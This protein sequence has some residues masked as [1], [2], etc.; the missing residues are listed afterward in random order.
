MIRALAEKELSAAITLVWDT[1]C[2][3]EAPEY[4]EEG[5]RSFRAFLQEDVLKTRLREGQM[6]FYGAFE[7][8]NLVGVAALRNQNHLCLLFV[9]RE[10]M[11]RGIGTALMQHLQMRVSEEGTHTLTVHASPYAIPF[12]H[13][14]GF[15]DLQSEQVQDGIRFT[16][17]RWDWEVIP[18][19]PHHGLC[20]RHYV[21]KGYS[22]EFVDNMTR[23][24]AKLKE[25]KQQLIRLQNG[26]DVLCACCPHHQNGCV[27]GQKVEQLDQTVLEQTGLQTG[28][29]LPWAAFQQRVQRDILEAEKFERVCGSCE[30]FKTCQEIRQNGESA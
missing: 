8:K 15:V 3:F 21:G 28:M 19:R 25:Q 26:G 1:F 9:S 29:L 12:Y 7:G 13:Q 22:A 4:S 30:W 11:R 18:L 16:P 20:I 2:A 5:V 17:M 24:V 27:S 6:S 23:I 14:I 10:T